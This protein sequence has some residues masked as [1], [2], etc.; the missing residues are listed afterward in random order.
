[1]GAK[2]AFTR[3]SFNYFMSE[4]VVRLRAR[5]RSTWSPSTGGSCCRSTAS[6]PAS[7]LWRHRD[8][9]ARAAPSLAD[10]CRAPRALAT[11]PESV[12]ARQLEAARRFSRGSTPR[13]RRTDPRLSEAFERVRWFPLPSEVA[14]R[15]REV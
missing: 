12:L 13:R 3:L 11:A 6:I 15:P 4:A 9:R 14:P 2:L 8:A 1:M 7:G 5:R 10:A